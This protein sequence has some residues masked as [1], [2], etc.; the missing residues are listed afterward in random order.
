MLEADSCPSWTVKY[1][2]FD[3]FEVF[4]GGILSTG[5]T[6]RQNAQFRHGK[7]WLI[8]VENGLKNSHFTFK[9]L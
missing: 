3:P 9:I 4:K 8:E 1:E 2:W 5:H 7:K 6:S